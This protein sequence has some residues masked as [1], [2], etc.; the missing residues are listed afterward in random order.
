WKGHRLCGNETQTPSDPEPLSLSLI[1]T[2]EEVDAAM[3]ATPH[4]VDEEFDKKRGFAFVT[5]DDHDSV[6][7]AVTQKHH[8]VNGH[9]YEAR[10]ASDGYGGRHGGDGCVGSRDGSNEF[11]N[12]GSNSGG[13]RND[14]DFG[15]YNNQSSDLGTMKGGNLAATAA[16]PIV[17]A[18]ITPSNHTVKAAVERRT[19]EVTENLRLQQICELSQNSDGKA[20]LVQR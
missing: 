13:G 18:A 10:K 6:D 8:G 1:A 19:N 12:D 3:S 20:Y 15:S 5:F 4:K 14:N 2:K 7:N 11:G 16:A 9:N 17:V